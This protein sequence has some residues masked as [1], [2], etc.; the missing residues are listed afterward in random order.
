MILETDF[1]F[2]TEGAG[3]IFGRKK[4]KSRTSMLPQGDGTVRRETEYD[5]DRDTLLCYVFPSP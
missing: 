3:S 1:S 5:E 2:T 4:N